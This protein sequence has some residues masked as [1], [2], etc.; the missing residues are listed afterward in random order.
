MNYTGIILGFF[1]LFA[2]G[3]GFVW[4]IKLESYVGACSARVV[5]FFGILLMAVTIF[6]GNF[7]V[8]AITGIIAGSVIWGASELPEQEKRAAKG[9][10]R[11]NPGK[12]CT[13]LK[14]SRLAQYI[15]GRNK[16]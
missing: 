1:T 10:F 14:N 2:I 3:I 4:V 9:I 13:K 11:D 7:W 15:N 6:I 5:L 12:V 16:V 8:A